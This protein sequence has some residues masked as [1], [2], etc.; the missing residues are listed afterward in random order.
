MKITKVLVNKLSSS[1]ITKR[2]H[3]KIIAAINAKVN[4]IWRFIIKISGR[5]LDWWAFQNDVSYGHGNG[6]SGGE[7]DPVADAELIEIHGENTYLDLDKYEYNEG[8]PTS[9]LWTDYETIVKEHVKAVK[10][11][12]SKKKEQKATAREQRKLKRA[13]VMESVKK[14]LTKEELKF[15]KFK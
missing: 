4:E 11:F 7:F 3:E 9:F 14:K 15:I 8:F 10:A 5:E 13:E 6:S 2:D 12:H 1:D